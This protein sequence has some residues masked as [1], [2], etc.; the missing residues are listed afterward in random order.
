MYILGLSAFYHNASACL[1]K[2]GQLLFALQ[3]ER[4]TRK[5]GDAHF[6]IKSVRQILSQAD[7]TI[8]DIGLVCYYENPQT[9]LERQLA[10]DLSAEDLLR[11]K[12]KYNA[13]ERSIR[14]NLGYTKEIF[15]ADHHQAHLG[16]GIFQSGW[17]EA[18]Y[19]TVDGV[20]EQDTIT[21][22]D[23]DAHGI[24]TKGSV[25]FP[26]SL[27]IFYSA[28][29][30]FLGFSVNDEEFKVMGLAAYG[31]PRFKS[32]LRENLFFD[33]GLALKLNT[34]FFQFSR[35]KIF[36][37]KLSTMLGISPRQPGEEISEVHR[38][39]ARSTQ[40]ILE[41]ELC[42]IIKQAF[43]TGVKRLIFCGGVAHNSLANQKLS[44]LAG[45]GE[46]FIPAAPNDVGSSVGACIIQSKLQVKINQRPVPYWGPDLDYGNHG[47]LERFFIPYDEGFIAHQLYLGQVIAVCRERM[48]FGDRALGHR[49]ILAHPGYP[50]IKDFL[51]AKV[52][53][54]EGYR[55]FAPVVTCE[56][57]A[58][59]FEMNEENLVMS[60]TYPVKELW[61]KSLSGVTHIDGTARVQTLRQGDNAWLYGLLR[62]FEKESALPVLINTSFNLNGEPI[63]F[64]ESEALDVFLR[65]DIDVLVLEDR[66]LIKN[67]VP[68]EW[69]EKYRRNV[70]S[71]S[72]YPKRETYDF[73]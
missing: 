71:S 20:G 48:E 27:G 1:F 50:G 67:D 59:Y 7:L 68:A 66:Y 47:T 31:Q 15:Y 49:S 34:D 65:T 73:L 36:S 30:A 56:D 18:A 52:K 54:R 33:S 64:N 23:Y 72:P 57:A 22:G 11:A 2:D 53:R 5:K 8:K 29:T 16:N 45:V 32:I 19:L 13:V 10:M 17:D 21:W 40:D 37:S 43:P 51:N 12:N 24:Q 61:R 25:H 14:S 3:E 70:K 4:L 28:L 44:A 60:K 58:T 41:E 63:V 39:I 9:K 38:D 6:P 46:V 26:H 62:A 55:P 35:E 69:L 42:S